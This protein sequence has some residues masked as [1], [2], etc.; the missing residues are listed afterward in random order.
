MFIGAVM[1]LKVDYP[2][3]ACSIPTLLCNNTFACRR[4][5]LY[6]NQDLYTQNSSLC[7]KSFLEGK[8]RHPRNIFQGCMS[9]NPDIPKNPS[10]STQTNK[11]PA[12]LPTV[13]LSIKLKKKGS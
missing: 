8:P 4:P 9:E 1:S 2:M 5:L 12:S 10:R 6:H 3:T 11:N 13:N 7:F